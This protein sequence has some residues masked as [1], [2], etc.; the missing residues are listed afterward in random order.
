MLYFTIWNDRITKNYTSA[1]IQYTYHVYMFAD[2][3]TQFFV[4]RRIHMVTGKNQPSFHPHEFQ[5]KLHMVIIQIIRLSLILIGFKILRTHLIVR[6][7]HDFN[8]ILQKN[9]K[10][11][12]IP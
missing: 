2:K 5:P 10:A 9:C 12:G 1:T 11:H 4:A 8:H 6:L 3:N 7:S